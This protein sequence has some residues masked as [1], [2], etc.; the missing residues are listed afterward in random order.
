M[1]GIQSMENAWALTKVMVVL[2]G[3][4]MSA[5]SFV[6]KYNLSTV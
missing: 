3:A 6:D 2:Y 1:S 4:L 5:V